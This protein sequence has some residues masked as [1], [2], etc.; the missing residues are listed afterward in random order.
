M[1]KKIYR[2]ELLQLTLLLSVGIGIL[3]WQVLLWGYVQVP[4]DIP[5]FFDPVMREAVPDMTRPQNPLLSDHI[6]Q[7]YVWHYLAAETMQSTGKIPLWNPYMLAGQPLVA[8]A[9]PA[10]Y[11]PI[12]WLLFWLDP[13]LVAAVRS[14]FNLFVAGF[15][16]FLFSRSLHISKEGAL[17]TAVAF[18]FSGTLIVGPGHAYANAL[19]WL[20]LIMWAGEMMLRQSRIYFWGLVASIGIGLSILGGHPESTFHNLLLFLLY[21]AARL[22]WLKTTIRAKGRLTGALV[23]ALVVGLLLGAVQWL[24]FT[25]WW[26]HSATPS[27][28]VAWGSESIFYTRDWLAHLGT[29]VT[30]LF[31]GF[32]GHP[33]DYTYQWPFA[34]FQ[35]YLEQSMYV[36]LIP[37]A[38]AAGALF[39]R[40]RREQRIIVIIIGVLA[41]I[42]L[43]VALRLPGFEVANHLPILDRVNN[44]RLK[45]YFSF[46]VAVLSGLGLDALWAGRPAGTGLARRAVYPVL[47]VLA[48]AWAIVL[49]VAVGKYGVTAVAEIPSDS[50]AHHLFFTIFSRQQARTMISLLVLVVASGAIV[51]RVWHKQS[52][53]PTGLKYLFIVV[54]LGELVVLAYGYNTLVP[55]ETIFP[56]IR[57]TETL[58]QDEETFRILTIPPAFWPNYGAVYGL[59]HVGGYDLPVYKR[60]ADIARAQGGAGYRQ[61]WSPEWPL[62]DWMN[63]KYVISIQPHDLEKLTLVFADTY[64]VYRNEAALPRTYMVYDVQVVA[65]EQQMLKM[66][67]SGDFPFGQ[68]VLLPY[69]L[70]PEQ[71]TAVSPPPAQNYRAAVSFVTYT[72]DEVVLAV[73]TETAG[74]LVMSD[75][76][77]PGWQALLNEQPVELHRAN[78]TF[79]AVFVPAGTHRVTF[80]YQ[81]LDFQIGRFLSLLGLLLVAIGLH[82]SYLGDRALFIRALSWK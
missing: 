25:A 75:V 15:F 5:P 13:G 46:L 61:V 10:L 22:F 55:R 33:V 81:P 21:M 38:L 42:M 67:T 72:N 60:Y 23:L 9:Q 47:A 27:R 1:L 6:Q 51:Y 35:N 54:T 4:A 52:S 19:V 64:H 82:R 12:N 66:M 28:S 58:R 56:P 8:N 11:Y 32:Y 59:Y 20:P 65:D 50:F 41:I 24:P 39:A 43:A 62:V 78:Y 69:D 17:L 40:R 70:P 44:T 14:M 30:L 71:A 49:V 76:Y 63:V 48:M 45:W 73:T 77:A 80:F 53:W 57:L 2:S 31:P 18:A 26:L 37:I 7:F 16:T 74:I 34:T 68:R 36:G 79:R 29:L 3:F